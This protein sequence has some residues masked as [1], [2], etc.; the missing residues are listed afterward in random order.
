MTKLGHGISA[1]LTAVLALLLL[2]GCGS[3]APTGAPD[4]GADADVTTPDAGTDAA[5]RSDAGCAR[6]D[7]DG[8]GHASIDCGGDDCNDANVG[9]HPGATEIAG[10]CID[11]D[12]DGLGG[13]DDDH[14][15]IA[16]ETCGGEDCDDARADVRP[17]ATEVVGDCVDQ[18]CDGFGDRGDDD[19]DGYSPAACAMGAPVD[20]DDT[21]AGLH[22]GAEDNAEVAGWVV[23]TVTLDAVESVG[24]SLVIE[25]GDVPSIA[26]LG[27]GALMKAD[28]GARSWILRP[29][30]YTGTSFASFP[31]WL[32]AVAGADGMHVAYMNPGVA[33]SVEYVFEERGDWRSERVPGV[34]GTPAVALRSDGSA[35]VSG[36]RGVEAL[37][38]ARR[39][40]PEDWAYEGIDVSAFWP[41]M[42]V[43]ASDH[44]HIAY[45]GTVYPSGGPYYYVPKYAVSGVGGAFT[46]ETIETLP[47]PGNI[48]EVIDI[49]LSADGNVHIVYAQGESPRQVRYATRGS[50][51]GAWTFEVIDTGAAQPSIAIERNGGIAVAYVKS[52]GGGRQE[53]RVALRTSSGWA[54]EV[55]GVL[56]GNAP[57]LAVDGRGTLHL[58]FDSSIAYNNQD[59]LYYARRGRPDGIDQNCDGVDGLDADHDGHA[60]RATGGGDCDDE[61]RLIHPAAIEVVGD[62]VD[63]NCN[64]VLDT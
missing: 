32:D 11:Q 52:A 3:E 63:Q 35:V 29:I 36:P 16:S 30:G 48:S 55:V 1:L 12:C 62:S 47:G 2:A 45:V 37:N 57:S 5:T 22:P 18:D 8:D 19:G 43:D 49:A 61:D 24:V 53:V 31:M 41:S 58:A 23:E 56:N 60:S 6:P 34:G 54:S 39:S 25:P 4:A 27:R 21:D 59:D 51:G 46:V 14:D 9:V 44:V 33:S 15:S 40:G 28:R 7:W 38:V 26:F 13:A 10:D 17:G 20:C 64:G 50:G 42:A